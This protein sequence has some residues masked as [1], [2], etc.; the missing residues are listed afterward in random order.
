L[1]RLAA[2]LASVGFGASD[3]VMRVTVTGHDGSLTGTPLCSLRFSRLPLL[4][5][6]VPLASS[7][8]LADASFDLAPE[9]LLARPNADETSVRISA[10]GGPAR[11]ARRRGS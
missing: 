4:A 3:A 2:L 6:T 8:G 5:K 1:L 9:R 11:G 10:S 7:A